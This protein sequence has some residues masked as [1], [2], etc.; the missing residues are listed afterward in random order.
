MPLPPHPSPFA[1]PRRP[2][3]DPAGTQQEQQAQAVQQGPPLQQQQEQEQQQEQQQRPGV[4]WL[5]GTGPGDPSL[6]T[7]KAVRLMQTADVVLYD[8]LVSG[9]ARGFCSCWRAAV[10][11]EAQRLASSA[12]RASE[13]RTRTHPAPL[14]PPAEDILGMVHPGAL[15]VYVGKQ[16]GFHTR[17]QEEIHELLGLFAGQGASVLR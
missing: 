7:L 9:G 17:S 6:L 15:L 8:R 2:P 14:P 12:A 11:S 16:R 4:V 1:A 13:P 5:V 3:A 10:A